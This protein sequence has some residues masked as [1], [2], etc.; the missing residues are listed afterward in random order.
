MALRSSD[1][2]VIY[3]N[4]Y[5]FPAWRGGPMF[6]AETLG[7]AKV[8]ARIEEFAQR[9]GR[10]LWPSNTTKSESSPKSHESPR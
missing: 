7:P 1:I 4:G 6:Y 10:D 2:D 5:G 3:M 8:R 9:H